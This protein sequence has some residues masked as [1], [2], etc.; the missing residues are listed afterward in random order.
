MSEALEQTESEDADAFDELYGLS[1]EIVEAVETAVDEGESPSAIRALVI[2]LH[3]ADLADLLERLPKDDRLAVVH[4]LGEEL[5]SDVFSYL[6][7]SVRESIVDE[8]PNAVLANIVRDLESDDVIDFLEDLD[9]EDQREILDSVPAEDRV[10]YEQSLSFPEYSAGRL[11]RR[12]TVTIPEFWTVGQ[13]IDFMRGEETDLPDDFY[14]LIV[15]TPA[16]KPVGLV[17]LSKLLRAKR[18]VPISAVMETDNKVMPADMDQEDVAFLFR[19]YGLVEAPVVDGDGRLVGVLTIDDIVDVM[20]EEHEDDILKLG[21]VSEDD[22]YSDFMETTRLRFSW[23]LVNLATAIVASLVIA[24]FEDALAKVVALAVLMPIVASMGGN[25]GTQ[26]LTVAVRALATNELT[27]KNALR[28]LVKEV[29]VGGANGI[30]FAI[31]MGIIAWLWFGDPLL[32]GV[33]ATAMIANLLIAGLSGVLIPLGIEKI[34]QDPAI[35]STVFLTTITD[36]V[37]FF[38]FLGLA[39]WVLL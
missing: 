3:A 39:S 18:V 21:G 33:I 15:V 5:D 17:Q 16:H 32:G 8:L 7:D 11:M 34:G 24:L 30:L 22:F 10:L 4:A 26:T 14:N 27:T 1:H 38:V 29:L 13:T 12:E 23:L 19:Q 28:I 31:I 37:G 9:E 25:A 36:V 6:D 2:P 20:D 35:A